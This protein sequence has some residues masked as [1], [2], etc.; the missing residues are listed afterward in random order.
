MGISG[1]LSGTAV[2]TQANGLTGPVLKK[3][4]P[5][6]NICW[7]AWGSNNRSLKLDQQLKPRHTVLMLSLIH[8]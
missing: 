5:P 3:A 1:G 6:P 4:K 2:R 8:I 7:A